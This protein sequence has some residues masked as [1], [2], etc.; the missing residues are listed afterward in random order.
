MNTALH[1]C[2]CRTVVLIFTGTTCMLA[3]VAC[4]QLTQTVVA[5]VYKSLLPHQS[6]VGYSMAP[7]KAC[8][9]QKPVAAGDLAE[10]LQTAV[11][12]TLTGCSSG[13]PPNSS[14]ATTPATAA[15]AAVSTEAA[16]ADAP[17]VWMCLSRHKVV[18]S[19]LLAAA[20]GVLS[21]A[22]FAEMEVKFDA[23]GKGLLLII[24][25]AGK[26]PRPCRWPVCAYISATQLVRT[27]YQ[28]PSRETSCQRAIATTSA[29]LHRTK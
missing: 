25:A 26:G 18:G 20:P 16:A 22:P 13:T 15:T 3:A 21:T 2:K 4:P 24:H 8:L 17:P 19:N 10:S 5:K 11:I 27:Q 28:S 7:A 12:K 29:E 9:S 6:A 1:Y 14:T 23:A